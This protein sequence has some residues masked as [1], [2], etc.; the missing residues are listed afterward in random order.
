LVS[1]IKESTETEHV[2]EQIDDED[3]IFG[4]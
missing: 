3:R 2:E 4:A 1:H